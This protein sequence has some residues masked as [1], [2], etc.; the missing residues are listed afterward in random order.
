MAEYDISV[1]PMLLDASSWILDGPF[2][3]EVQLDALVLSPGNSELRL[4][5]GSDL[6][7]HGRS[8]RSRLQS[9]VASSVILGKVEATA[10]ILCSTNEV[11]RDGG[12]SYFMRCDVMARAEYDISVL[13]IHGMRWDSTLG[14]LRRQ[15]GWE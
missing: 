11:V 7:V 2:L 8:G 9:D 10:G 3:I 1:F 12:S 6:S 13:Q 14:W 5:S 4:R 15:A